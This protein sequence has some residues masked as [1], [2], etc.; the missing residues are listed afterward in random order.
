VRTCVDNL[1]LTEEDKWCR[2]H[3]I[4]TLMLTSSSWHRDSAPCRTD[5]HPLNLRY[6]PAHA[7]QL[8]A[9][10][11]TVSFHTFPPPLVI[12]RHGDASLTIF[13]K[14]PTFYFLLFP[15]SDPIVSL[16]R[17][18]SYHCSEF[19]A[20]SLLTVNKSMPIA[21]FSAFHVRAEPFFKSRPSNQMGKGG[22]LD[23]CRPSVSKLDPEKLD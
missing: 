2:V 6:K 14:N 4:P 8:N 17:H 22:F 3:L 20:N 5:G 19:P 1:K 9:S 10:L 15:Q 7:S 12:Y 18:T 16:S 13:A 21:F 23:S 11:F